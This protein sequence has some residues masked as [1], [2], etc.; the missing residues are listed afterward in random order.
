MWIATVSNIHDNF[1]D[2]IVHGTSWK[3]SNIPI[4]KFRF[5][6]IY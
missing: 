2:V 6:K 4:E 3:V 5:C 1:F